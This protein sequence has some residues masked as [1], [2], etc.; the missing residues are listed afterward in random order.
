MDIFSHLTR[1]EYVRNENKCLVYGVMIWLNY[2]L[3]IL[4]LPLLG[5]VRLPR[6]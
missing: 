1:Q 5:A 2:D 4:E 3:F 6:S